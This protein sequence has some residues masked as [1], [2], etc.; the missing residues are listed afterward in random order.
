MEYYKILYDPAKSKLN[1]RAELPPQSQKSPL[2]VVI[3]KVSVNLYFQIRGVLFI[4]YFHFDKSTFQAN[5]IVINTL[6]PLRKS[7]LFYIN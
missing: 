5:Y 3:V 7:P 2:P 4:H 1:S 6:R